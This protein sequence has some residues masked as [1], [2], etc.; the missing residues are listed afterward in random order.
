LVETGSF[1][2]VEGLTKGCGGKGRKFHIE[3]WLA[4]LPQPS[5]LLPTLPGLASAG[6]GNDEDASRQ[7]ELLPRE[8]LRPTE[9]SKERSIR[10]LRDPF[11][12]YVL[13]RPLQCHL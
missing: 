7:E 11:F 6:F 9:S 10:R 5:S 2:I 13:K 8:A 1:G 4:L 3:G 12:G